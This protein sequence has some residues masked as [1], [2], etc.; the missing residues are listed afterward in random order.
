M[1]SVWGNWRAEGKVCFVKVSNTVCNGAKIN[2]HNHAFLN[3]PFSTILFSHWQSTS[4]Y[5]HVYGEY[6]SGANHC[7]YVQES[8][9]CIWGVQGVVSKETQLSG[10]TP[11]CMGSTREQSD[12][13][14]EPQNHPHV[15]G[16]YRWCVCRYVLRC[17]ITPMCMGS[18]KFQ[19]SD[20]FPSWNHP[21]VYGEY[22]ITVSSDSKS[23]ESP[24]CVWGVRFVKY[25][26][27]SMIR[28][29]PMCMG[30]TQVDYRSAC[31]SWESPP[32]LWGI[33]LFLLKRCRIYRITPMCMG[34][35]GTNIAILQKL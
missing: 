16:E 21:H 11:M 27:T 6:T 9:P 15:Y 19:S 28:I 30:S 7:L 35:T 24:P 31:G 10:I 4:N 25:L 2:R 17:G 29:T 34:S 18:T 33:Q 23:L 26:R 20:A 32:C 5:P 22:S 14:S 3:R 8:P 1:F 13:A 12:C